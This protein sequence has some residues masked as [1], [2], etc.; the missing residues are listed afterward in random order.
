MFPAT[1]IKVL[2]ASP[3]DVLQECEAI[4]AAIYRWNSLHAENTG[5]MLLP[6]RWATH[7][8]PAMGAPAQ[9]ILNT[10]I[11]DPSDVIVACFGHRIGTPTATSESG[12]S[13]EIERF[14]ATNRPAIIYFSN[15][16]AS[17]GDINPDQLQRRNDLRE[18]WQREGLLGTYTSISD[19][20][21]RIDADLIRLVQEFNIETAGEVTTLETG[22]TQPPTTIYSS[23]EYLRVGLLRDSV[24]WKSQWETRGDPFNVDA[25]K[26]LA[27]GIYQYLA[28]LNG[29]IAVTLNNPSPAL[30][31]DIRLLMQTAQQIANTRFYIDGGRSYTNFELQ[32][33]LLMSN[34][35]DLVGRDWQHYIVTSLPVDPNPE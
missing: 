15:S 7:S 29:D 9:E 8:R 16:Q 24:M 3:S 11:V 2:I 12:T 27:R 25:A 6:I 33:D 22:S 34:V 5:K 10:Q 21:R 18:R 17:I 26:E 4:E 28:Q 13:E 31:G 20:S 30:G 14:I 35:E 19:L 1:V 23:L 32:M